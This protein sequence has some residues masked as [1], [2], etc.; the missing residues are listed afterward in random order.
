VVLCNGYLVQRLH[1]HENNGAQVRAHWSLLEALCYSCVLRFCFVV[2]V[3][4]FFLF[5]WFVSSHFFALGNKNKS[6]IKLHIAKCK[7]TRQKHIKKF[8]I[9]TRMQKMK[10]K[11]K[12]VTQDESKTKSQEF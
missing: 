8:T 2:K 4:I 7:D 9:E 1:V 11:N 3:A 10:H 6:D 5:F 12:N